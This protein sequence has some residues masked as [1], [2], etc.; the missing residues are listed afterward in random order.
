MRRVLT[1]DGGGHQVGFAASFLS[2]IEASERIRIADYFD[3]IAGIGSGGVLAIALGL[4]VPAKTL[5]GWGALDSTTHN[6]VADSDPTGSARLNELRRI[7]AGTLSDIFQ[8]KQLSDSATRLLIP[9]YDDQAGEVIVF[10]SEPD[11]AAPSA[12][13]AAVAAATLSVPT[14]DTAY[15]ARHSPAA[16]ME[17]AV[18]NNPLDIAV[19]RAFGLWGQGSGGLKFLS[20]GKRVGHS[21]AAPEQMARHSIIRSQSQF[22]MELARTLVGSSNVLRVEYNDRDKSVQASN[23]HQWHALEVGEAEA[24]RLMPLLKANYLARPVERPPASATVVRLDFDRGR[25][26]S[27]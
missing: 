26:R 4:N 9:G 27:A 16:T 13:A 2:S 19:T 8:G 3:I 6:P 12:S 10:D 25:K 24:N 11:G 7:Q 22:A 14:V 18:S 17:C 20:I 5:M 15:P 23:D 1:I 21:D